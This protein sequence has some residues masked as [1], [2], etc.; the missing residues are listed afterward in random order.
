MSD[1]TVEPV[2][3]SDEAE[4]VDPG[5]TLALADAVVAIAMTLLALDLKPTL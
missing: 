2:Q 3:H 4:G 1:A 5:R